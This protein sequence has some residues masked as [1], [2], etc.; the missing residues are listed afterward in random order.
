MNSFTYQSFMVD[1]LSGRIDLFTNKVGVLLVTSDYRPDV[2]MHMRRGDIHGEVVGA[3]YEFGGKVCKLGISVAS[4]LITIQLPKLTWDPSTITACG[5]V[6]YQARG[7]V[8]S[9]DELIAYVNLGNQI[10]TAGAFVLS[11]SPMIIQ[12]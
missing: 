1:A 11:L 3:G 2:A 12:F 4:R 6:A 9:E 10:S 5:A 7:G 8:S